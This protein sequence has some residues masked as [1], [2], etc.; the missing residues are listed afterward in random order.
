MGNRGTP[1]IICKKQKSLKW[2]IEKKRCYECLMP[3]MGWS[4]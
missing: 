3:I 4:S 1:C 2:D